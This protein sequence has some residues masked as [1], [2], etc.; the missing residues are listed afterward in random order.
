M[1]DQANP[2]QLS[3]VRVSGLLDQRIRLALSHVLAERSRTLGG[4]GYGGAWGG[5]QHGRWIGAVAMATAYVKESIPAL[6]DIVHR[7]V[8]NQAPSGFF[9]ET[10]NSLTW[11]GA[12]RALIG[13][14]EY[15]EVT[16]DPEALQAATRLGGFYLANFPMEA[17][18][19]MSHHGGH[20]EGLVALWRITGNLDYLTLAKKIPETVEQDFG[21]PGNPTPSHHTHSYLSVMRGCVDLFLATNEPA[22]LL[23]AQATWDHILSYQMWV[24]GGISE[25]S[26]YPFETRDETCSV[27]DWLRLS[28][29]LW[30]A[31]RDP[32]Y[33]EVAEHVL[34]NHIFFDQDHTGGFCCFRSI[35]KPVSQQVRDVVAWFCC[36]MHGL[37]ALLEA[38]RFIYTYETNVIAIN[39]LIDS[40]AHL[41]ISNHSVHVKQVTD[42]STNRV[43]VEVTPDEPIPFTLQ[44]RIPKWTRS[45]QVA[46]N[47]EP[48][49]LDT[50]G[51][52]VSVSRT[53]R[54]KDWLEISLEIGFHIVPAKLNSFS[55]LSSPPGPAKSN[56]IEEAAL[57][58]GP[59]VLMLD[60]SL[61][62][63]DMLEWE[64]AEILVP[65]TPTG[66]PF[67]S[68]VEAHILGRGVLAVP[69]A[70]FMT[71]ARRGDVQAGPI[72]DDESWK[73]AFLVPISEVT[74]RWTYSVQRVVPY[75]I[76][77]TLRLLDKKDVNDFEVRLQ[78]RFQEF[79]QRRKSDTA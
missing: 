51:G 1:P 62:I 67:L 10:C 72:T 64:S 33:M 35:G 56:P 24:S 52:S 57:I 21:K 58:Y 28:F 13:L 27:A 42:S 49:S 11:W 29:K 43:R 20:E 18:G 74:D 5:D 61:N 26:N 19:L 76:R 47:D 53:W 36:S 16:G 40:E 30:Q 48:L 14:L 78:E 75:E 8:R 9:G 60:P 3:S 44:V 22:F 23:R 79:I 17:P 70:C 45:F 41:E 66:D 39:L 73:L 32:K 31:T 50:S 46:L 37:R 34:L 71:L 68:K 25:G 4:E 6:A 38:T 77:N 12:G 54:P 59:Y 63:Y 2:L 15:W 69:D 65:I 7:L 55:M